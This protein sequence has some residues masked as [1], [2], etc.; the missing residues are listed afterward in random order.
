M[1]RMRA[2]ELISEYISDVMVVAC[3][4][5]ISR[6]LFTIRDQP[7]NFYMIGSMGLASSI[8]LGV[9]MAQPDK[10]VMTLD[11]DGN[12]LMNTGTLGSIAAIGPKN[13]F[14]IAL[15]NEAYGSTGDQKSISGHFSLGKLADAFGYKNVFEVDNEEELTALLPAYFA[16]EGPS[17]LHIKVEKGQ[18]ENTNR[19]SWTPEEMT[20]RFRK[21]A[22]AE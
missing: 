2:I 7:S 22:L 16:T 5:F 8:G 19:V 20:A 15:D 1:K 18:S 13:F 3:N 9:A 14:H 12:I 6:E 11:G 10:K 17:F 21:T 4:G